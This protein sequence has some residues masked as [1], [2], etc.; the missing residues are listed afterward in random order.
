MT[1]VP[2]RYDYT[3]PDNFNVN[4]LESGLP[5]WLIVLGFVWMLL[6]SFNCLHPVARFLSRIPV[7]F[8]IYEVGGLFILY[9]GMMRGMRP[10]YRPM[11]VFWIILLALD[12]LKMI[13]FSLGPAADPIHP[14]FPILLLIIYIPLGGLIL[15]WYRGRLQTV[16]I[17]MIVRILV[18]VVLYLVLAALNIRFGWYLDVAVLVT[19]IALAVSLYR[20]LA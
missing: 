18:M 13:L 6:S 14:F 9:I 20:V 19:N 3:R 12:L 1:E 11:T 8:P 15:I 10:L 16:G 5:R 2:R 7:F 4:H 17:W